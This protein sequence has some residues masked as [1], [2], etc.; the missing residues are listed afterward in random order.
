MSNEDHG[1]APGELIIPDNLQAWFGD[2]VRDAVRRT[3]LQADDATLWYLVNLLC[4][5]SRTDQVFQPGSDGARLPI[6]VDYYTESL[7]APTDREREFALQRMGD[8]ALFVAGLYADSLQRRL[9]DID[10]YIAM[11][12]QAYAALSDRLGSGLRARALGQ[13]FAELGRKFTGF[14]DVLHEVAEATLPID[15]RDWMRTYEVWVRTGSPRAERLLRERG[16]APS[17]QA[18]LILH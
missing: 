8:V 7:E 4:V 14:V 11:G 6:L 5:F 16:I 10:Y 13:V 12:R 2:C 1:P 9:V 17:P 3:S 15:R 18:G